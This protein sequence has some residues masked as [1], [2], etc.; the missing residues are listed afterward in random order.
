VSEQTRNTNE[1]TAQNNYRG[2]TEADGDAPFVSERVQ[3][4]GFRALA[5]LRS[6]EEQTVYFRTIQYVERYHTMY[7]RAANGSK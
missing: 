2:H 4:C 1:G 6:T 5:R 7:E 3:L